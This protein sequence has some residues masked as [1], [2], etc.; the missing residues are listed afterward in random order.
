MILSPCVSLL[1]ILLNMTVTFQDPQF[2]CYLS[3][4]PHQCP[5]FPFSNLL[6]PVCLLLGGFL[7]DFEAGIFLPDEMPTHMLRMPPSL[8]IVFEGV[9]S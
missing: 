6:S 2:N 5:S 8:D 1:A 7:V 4:T 3:P 9:I